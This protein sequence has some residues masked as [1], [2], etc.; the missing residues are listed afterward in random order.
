MLIAFVLF[1]GPVRMTMATDPWLVDGNHWYFNQPARLA[2]EALFVLSVGAVL[3]ATGQ[4][5]LL[6]HRVGKTHLFP[7]LFWCGL[8]AAL[9]TVARVDR[10]LPLIEPP[11]IG[12]TLLWF[13]TGLFIGIGQ[14]L[15]FRGLLF[16]G[17][18]AFLNRYWTWALSIFIFVVAPLHSYRLF[19]YWQDGRDERALFLAFVYLMAGILFTWL[20]ARTQS[21]LVPGLIHALANALTFS[22]T[23]TLVGAATGP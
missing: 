3:W 17:L 5:R 14:E 20:R 15:T 8:I 6:F 22:L 7:L 4:S 10:W 9:F 2:L 12:A 18:G 1:E 16:T 21:L 19:I 13:A 11:I 23:F